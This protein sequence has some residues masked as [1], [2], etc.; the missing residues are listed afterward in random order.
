MSEETP[1]KRT[2]LN[3]EIEPELKKEVEDAADYWGMKLNKFIRNRIL[4]LGAYFQKHLDWAQTEYLAK[5]RYRL[6]CLYA[7]R[8][9]FSHEEGYESVVA[10]I[11]EAISEAKAI[12]EASGKEVKSE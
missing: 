4:P 12:D 3:V 7:A 9:D 11:D 10:K 6:V 1:K 2:Q 5:R 8:N